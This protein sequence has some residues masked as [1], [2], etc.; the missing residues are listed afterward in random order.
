MPMKIVLFLGAG[1][2]AAWKLPV[3]KRFFAVAEN[4]DRLNDADRTFLKRIRTKAKSA[5]GMIVSEIHDLEHV[6]SFALM[7]QDIDRLRTD[8]A[9]PEADRLRR[10]L[11]LV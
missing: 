8:D 2:S 5:A 4:H 9:E 11:G 6:L 10:I 7:A 3:M 1:F